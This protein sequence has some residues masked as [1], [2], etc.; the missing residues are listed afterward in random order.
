MKVFQTPYGVIIE[1]ERW[2]IAVYINR[3]DGTMSYIFSDHSPNPDIVYTI[4]LEE[5]GSFLRELN[6][7]FEEICVRSNAVEVDFGQN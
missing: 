6:M 2:P 5:C 4:P 7:I 1:S 3:M